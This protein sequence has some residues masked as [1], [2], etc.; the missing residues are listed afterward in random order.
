[1]SP[2]AAMI[3]PKPSPML[4][5]IFG[6]AYGKYESTYQKSYLFA[7]LD[8]IKWTDSCMSDTA[9]EDSSHHAFTVVIEVVD[10]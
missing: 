4:E 1:M 7:A 8:N 5:Y 10:V 6:F 3:L 9:C 2:S